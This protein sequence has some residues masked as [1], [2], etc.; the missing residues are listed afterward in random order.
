MP[1]KSAKDRE[2]ELKIWEST[3]VYLTPEGHEELKNKLE[4][5]RKK[6]PELVQEVSRTAAYGDRSENDE[7]KTAKGKLRATQFQIAK[8]DDQ[9]RKVR[10]I[11]SGSSGGKIHIGSTARV[12]SK[13]K[14]MTFRIVGPHEAS[15]VEGRISH[16]SPL[17]KALIGHSEGDV[18]IFESGGGIK[19]YKILEIH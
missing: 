6:I 9:L 14:Q 10:I 5:L 11:P 4:R 19:E 18:V 15:P 13:G 7:Y 1:R 8:I 16:E 17:G 12:E 3:P 2:E